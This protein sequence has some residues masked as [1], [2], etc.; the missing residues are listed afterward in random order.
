MDGEGGP[1]TPAPAGAS[2]QVAKKAKCIL[3]GGT[4]PSLRC[5][6]L[7]PRRPRHQEARLAHMPFVCQKA[8]CLRVL[9]R[10]YTHI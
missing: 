5:G 6:E 9:M 1:Q 4:W 3:R 10:I 2:V 7:A 8:F